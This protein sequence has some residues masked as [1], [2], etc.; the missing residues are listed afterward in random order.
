[1]FTTKPAEGLQDVV[2]KL[3]KTPMTVLS[4]RLNEGK[5]VTIAKAIEHQRPQNLSRFFGKEGVNRWSILNKHAL[6]PV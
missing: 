6:T 3:F 4:R 2:S 5:L 1:M